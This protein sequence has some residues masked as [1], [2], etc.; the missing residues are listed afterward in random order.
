MDSLK[1]KIGRSVTWRY[2]IALSLV[3]ALSTGAFLGLFLTI[4][5]EEKRAE[6]IRE[7]AQQQATSQRI[8]LFANAYAAAKTD[9]DRNEYRHELDRAVRKMERDHHALLHAN[10]TAMAVSCDPVSDV[11]RRV[12]GPDGSG[13]GITA[14][15]RLAS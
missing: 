9:L 14:V 3:A 5:S 4:A 8:A 6:L 15:R 10:A 1:L 11:A 13:V 7:L 12:A 2:M